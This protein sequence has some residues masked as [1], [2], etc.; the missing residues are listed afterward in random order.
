MEKLLITS[1]YNKLMKLP[2][3]FDYDQPFDRHMNV[4]EHTQEL[5]DICKKYEI[6]YHCVTLKEFKS[7]T[8]Q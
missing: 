8:G 5:E 1:Q 4:F 3:S 6:A 7:M 2:I